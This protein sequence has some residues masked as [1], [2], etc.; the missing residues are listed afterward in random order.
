ML[1][2][3]ARAGHDAH[4]LTYAHGLSQQDTPFTHHR[5]RAPALTESM[6]SGPS[7]AKIALDLALAHEVREVVARIKPTLVVAHHIEAAIA[8]IGLPRPTAYVAHTSLDR[9]LPTYSNAKFTRVLGAAGNALDAVAIRTH[10]A[11]AAIAPELAEHLRRAHHRPVRYLPLPWPM[12]KESAISMPEARAHYGIDTEDFVLAY[13]GN[14]DRYQG[15]E[16]LLEAFAYV[17]KVEP[18]ARLVIA[19]ASDQT[20]LAGTLEGHPA[21]ERISILALGDESSRTRIHAL[22][23]VIAVPRA[24]AGGVPIKLLDALSRQKPVVT[25]RRATAGLAVQNACVVCADDSADALARGMLRLLSD[26]SERSM[27]ASGTTSYM[28]SEH[29]DSAFL[30]AFAALSEDAGH[31]GSRAA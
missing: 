27:I 1:G 16:Q 11:S 9:E 15:I 6:R 17:A 10:H 14:L 31:Q 23:D 26:A 28:Q 21:R 24:V 20:S 22:A 18:R 3:L 12:A 30:E 4:L 25:V 13:V 5:L 7:V 19:T 2:S 8:C 29:S